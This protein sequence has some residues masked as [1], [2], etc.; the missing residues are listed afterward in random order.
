M[1]TY[2][3]EDQIRTKEDLF[4]FLQMYIHENISYTDGI[5]VKEAYESLAH[6]DWHSLIRLEKI[7]DASKNA[8]ET[9]KASRMI[10]K[11]FLQAILPVHETENLHEWYQLFRNQRIYGHFPM[12]YTLYTY[13]MEFDVYT[14][15]LTFI[16]SS[17]VGLVHNAVRA[18]PLGQKGGIEVIHRLIPEMEKGA[19]ITLNRSL[20]DLSNHAIGLELASMNHKFLPSRLFIS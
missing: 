2:I 17:T 8:E 6:K 4:Q 11:Q 9:R 5:F 19:Q 13:D 18:I 15:L 7:C 14:T 3:Q 16:Y 12:A 20:S 10:G 1:E